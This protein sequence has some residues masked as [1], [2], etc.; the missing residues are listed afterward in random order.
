MKK[1]RRVRFVDDVRESW[2]WLSMQL[3][4]L[5]AMLMLGWTQ[6]PKELQQHLDPRVVA[7]TAFGIFVLGM[8]GRIITT[9][10]KK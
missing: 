1:K 8:F 10:E 5:G 6:L 2:K 3:Q 9:E 7:W 4:S